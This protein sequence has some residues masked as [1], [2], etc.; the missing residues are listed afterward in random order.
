MDNRD[1]MRWQQRDNTPWHHPSPPRRTNFI[2]AFWRGEFSLGVSYWLFGLLVSVVALL[3]QT[4]LVSVLPETFDPEAIFGFI[5]A[6]WIGASA[7][8]V[9]QV[10]GVWRSASRCARERRALGKHRFWAR[11]AQVAIALSVIRFVGEFA[12]V[13]IPQLDETYQMAFRND[14]DIPD[15]RITLLADGSGVEVAGGF[16]FGLARELRRVLDTAPGVQFVH[17]DSVGGRSGEAEEV[18]SL[19]R[20]RGLSTY[21]ARYCESACVIAF[22][23]GEERWIDPRGRIGLHSP[24]FP[25]LSELEL[26]GARNDYVAFLAAAGFDTALVRRGMA[27]PAASMWYP[28]ID[29]LI[30]ARAVTN[31]AGAED[32]RPVAR[33]ANEPEGDSKTYSQQEF[34]E[35]LLEVGMFRSIKENVPDDF[36]KLVKNITEIANKKPSVEQIKKAVAA[37]TL[38]VRAKYVAKIAQTS[39][40]HLKKLLFLHLDLLR[41]ILRSEGIQHCNSFAAY[42]G[43]ALADFDDLSEYSSHLNQFGEEYFAAVGEAL[44]NPINR[45]PA[46]DADWERLGDAMYDNGVPDSYLDV[47]VDDLITDQDYCAAVITMMEAI[48]VLPGDP[49]VRLRSGFVSELAAQ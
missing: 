45:A 41:E 31:V 48:L 8:T 12:T 21:V 35:F 24:D 14:P 25:G 3:F 44:E 1:P 19:I 13:G 32:F 40:V 10:V 9:W 4:A 22:A 29:E 38:Y 47:L 36:D 11:A 42:G 16:K 20:R 18:F 28:T 15:Y 34:V 26:E 33:S 39:D 30:E 17:L 37:E 6:L 5:L 27:I 46:T 43:R 23:G 7:L 2:V 49:G